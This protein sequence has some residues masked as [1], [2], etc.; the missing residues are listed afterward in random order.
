MNRRTLRDLCK[1]F[2][3][4]EDVLVIFREAQRMAR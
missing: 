2:C 1:P 4:T 3:S